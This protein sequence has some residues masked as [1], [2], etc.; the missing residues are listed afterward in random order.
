MGD[1]MFTD[2]VTMDKI[3]VPAR[4]FKLWDIQSNMN[5]QFDDR[6]MIPT[7]TQFSVKQITAPVSGSVY[8]EN[9]H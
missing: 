2:D 3:I 6:Y 4:S 8:L 1:V 9:I 5:A 7:G